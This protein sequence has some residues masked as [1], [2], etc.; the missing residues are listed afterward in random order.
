MKHLLKLTPALALLCTLMACGTSKAVG[1]KS[2]LAGSW[3]T[4][5]PENSPNVIIKKDNKLLVL[6]TEEDKEEVVDTLRFNYTLKGEKLA[7]YMDNKLVSKSKLL[8]L[9]TD[10]LSYLREKDN[11]IFTYKRK[12]K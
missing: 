10:S 1:D 2:L 9:T 5:T 4:I 12:A 8:K 3:I 11:E 6:M 7:L